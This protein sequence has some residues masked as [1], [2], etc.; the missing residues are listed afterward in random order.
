MYQNITIQLQIICDGVAQEVYQESHD[1]EHDS[2][3]YSLNR[4]ACDFIEEAGEELENALISKQK[5]LAELQRN[6]IK[7]KRTFSNFAPKAVVATVSDST[8]EQDDSSDTVASSTSVTADTSVTRNT[9]SSFK[10]A[11][12]T[13]SADTPDLRTALLA[14]QPDAF[15]LETINKY[16]LPEVARAL[17]AH[18]YAQS[19][20]DSYVLGL[21]NY[22]YDIAATGWESPFGTEG[23]DARSLLDELTTRVFRFDSFELR[24]LYLRLATWLVGR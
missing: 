18:S 13:A 12:A 22:S 10:S 24:A 4:I 21:Y 23:T 6:E 7:S 16:S 1:I 20:G 19:H 17:E 14:A 9:F 3:R 2:E 8:A 5:A 15:L 11:P